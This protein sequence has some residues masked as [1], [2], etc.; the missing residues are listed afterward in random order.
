MRR[1]DHLYHYCRLNYFGTLPSEK[2]RKSAPLTFFHLLKKAELVMDPQM[3]Q[4]LK[5][6]TLST[7]LITSLR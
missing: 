4:A 5:I 6:Y 3:T 1:K 2:I 7:A